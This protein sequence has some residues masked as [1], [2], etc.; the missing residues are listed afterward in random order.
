[1]NTS[2]VIVT[3]RPLSRPVVEG[4]LV[5]GAV[6][7]VPC[8]LYS[9]GLAPVLRVAYPAM[10]LALAAWLFA[11]RSP[12]FAGHCVLLFCFVSLVRRLVDDQAGFD[13]ASPVLI[14][15]YLCCLFT[16][17]AFLEYWLRP[18]PEYLG[19]FLVILLAILYGALLAVLQGAVVAAVID[20]LKW[21]AGPLLAV[22][23][24]ARRD[25][26]LKEREIVEQSLVWAG[27]LM[28]LYGVFQYIS[29]PSWDLQWMRGVAELGM[30]SIG[31]PEPFALRV[32]STMNSPGSL[33][34]V[35]SAGIL[36]AFKRPLHVAVP[37]ITLMLLGLAL[38]QYRTIWAATLFGAL[39][40]IFARPGVF[41]PANILAALAVIVGLSATALV[42]QIRDTVVQR[43]SSMSN[44]RADQSGEERL[45]Q[46]RALTRDEGLIVGEGLGQIGVAR[47]LGGMHRVVL[48][49]ALIEIWRGLGV[50]AGT[51][52][53]G[54]LA[55]LVV[56]LF[57]RAPDVAQ[58]LHFDR[59][60]VI[61][62]WVQLPMG[63]V[64]TGENGFFAWLFLGLGLAALARSAPR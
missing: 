23:L 55:V 52:Y 28:G 12:W 56:T 40:L 48:D 43:A 26:H 38:A 14:T 45:N 6:L 32:F 8:L 15:P 16:G 46:Y 63:S 35:L 4:G 36:V 50:V 53:L 24:L 64:H 57:Q 31:Q 19:G 2:A 21:S 9:L 59:A 58:H 27:A 20:F 49:S 39:L 37:V 11:R 51:A 18:R 10:N 1:V 5:A 7:L 30:D 61:A 42:P 29:P 33:G 47:R 62:A 44:L 17:L 13:P 41:R 34:A 3:A 54:A 25:Q 60:I 22:Y